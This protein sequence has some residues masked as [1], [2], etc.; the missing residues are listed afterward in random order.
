MITMKGRVVNFTG[1]D[2]KQLKELAASLG[3][4][5]QETFELALTEHMK[6]SK[7]VK[8]TNKRSK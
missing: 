4:T 8:K 7:T 6:Q 1:K 2:A 5:E 3:K